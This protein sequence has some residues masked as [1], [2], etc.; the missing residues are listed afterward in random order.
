MITLRRPFIAGLLAL[1]V[2]TLGG[3][4][5]RHQRRVVVLTPY[6]SSIFTHEF[7]GAFR[8]RA[9]KRGWLVNVIDTRGDMARLANRLQ[10]VVTARADAII[11]ISIMP[12]HIADQIS[13]A[14][15]AKIPLIVVDGKWIDGVTTSLT[16][17]NYAMGRQISQFLVDRLGGR[18]RIVKFYHS[19][20][21][22]VFQREKALADVLAKNPGITV[23]AEHY[24]KV[25]GPIEDAKK[26]M[27]NILLATGGAIDGVWA[28]WDEPAIGAVLALDEAGAQQSII[29]VGVDGNPQASEMVAACSRFVA[30]VKQDFAAMASRTASELTALFAGSAASARQITIPARLIT[31]RD[32][33]V[34]CA[35]RGK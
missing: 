12:D 14:A 15:Q 23:V 8:E 4:G 18:G 22:G 27:A 29:V 2:L 28:A 16:S 1:A 11:L 21:P 20:H 10:D 33:G 24:V 17:D 30:T 31:V 35:N 7:L 9:A 25:P 3:C 26:A 32:L 34:T 13:Q 6:L 19:A 5:P